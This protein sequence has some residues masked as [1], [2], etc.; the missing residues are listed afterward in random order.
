MF[1]TRAA[2]ET[3]MASYTAAHRRL[4]FVFHKD[5]TREKRKE[6]GGDGENR[7]RMFFRA[8]GSLPTLPL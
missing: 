4:I 3:G 2:E 5:I 8:N 6:H 1:I 7:S